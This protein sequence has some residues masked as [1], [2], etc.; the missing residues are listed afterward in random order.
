[1]PIIMLTARTQPQDKI[2]G[3]Q[4]GADDYITKPFLLDE[5]LA[6]V[7]AVLRRTAP[8][9]QLLVLGDVVIDFTHLRAWRG[10]CDLALNPREFALLQY[11]AEH[12]GLVVSREN[13]LRHVWGFSQPPLSRAVD[14][15]VARLRR[16]IESDAQHPRFIR[17]VH[18][19][20]Y[21][22]VLDT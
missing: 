18:G 19:D 14:M 4:S 7:H 16:K 15:F 2:R 8:S 9:S 17:T 21:R 22:L 12:S 20:G 5:L 1:V 13:L 3:L 10:D 11:L 6:R